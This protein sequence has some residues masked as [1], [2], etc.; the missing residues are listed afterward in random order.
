MNPISRLIPLLLTLATLIA[1]GCSRHA[2]TPDDDAGKA[3]RAAIDSLL[4]GNADFYREW[5]ESEKRKALSDRDSDRWAECLVQEGI[6]AFYSADPGVMMAK[7]DSALAC[8]LPKPLTPRRAM[9]IH[10]AYMTKGGYY[11]QYHFNADSSIYYHTVAVDYAR[12]A[13]KG[14]DYSIALGNLAD[15]YKLAT[16]LAEASDYY[17]RAIQVAD[18]IGSTRQD[19]IPLYGGLAAT[20]TQLRDFEQSREWWDKTMALY[21]VMIPFEKFNNLNNLGND[22]YYR[23]D[24]PQALATFKRLATYLDSL[25]QA[26]WE[27]NFVAVNL[28]DSYLYLNHPDSAAPLITSSLAY[29]SDVQRNPVAL[30]YLHTLLMRLYMERGNYA[31][32]EDLIERHPLSDTLRVEEQTARL[33]VMM[34]YYTKTHQWQQAYQARERQNAIDD[35]LRSERVS[36]LAAARRIQ[37]SHDTEMLRLR[38][39]QQATAAHNLRLS[40]IIFLAIVVIAALAVLM[41]LMRLRGRRRE[42]KVHYDMIALRMQSVRSRITPHFI[43]NALNHEV[44]ARQTGRP[45]HLKSIVALLRHQQYVAEELITPLSD[46]LAF[47]DNYVAVERE[48]IDGPFEYTVSVDERIDPEKTLGP[49]MTI[50]IL[51]ENAFKHGFRLMPPDA[52]KHL[53]VDARLDEEG[54]HVV[55]VFGN[56]SPASLSAAPRPVAKGSGNGLKIIMQTLSYI[57]SRAHADL[58]FDSRSGIHPLWGEGVWSILTIPAGTDLSGLAGNNP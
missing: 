8:L 53:V 51:V 26:E 37:Y 34:D 13:G 6:A 27:R 33:K 54:N 56:S 41:I 44:L 50:Q 43:F 3:D 25:P 16:R 57:N 42:E 15:S 38:G 48:V 45:S 32:V 28:A 58:R 7:S 22:Y 47:V 10:R 14:H 11:S 5:F 17:H 9:A 39:D 35:T 21:D 29:F 2:D 19:Y 23:Q 46:E 40:L 30:A 31:A 49:S 55:T 36:Q 12:E 4:A 24:Y 20:Y 52:P 1:G 18:S